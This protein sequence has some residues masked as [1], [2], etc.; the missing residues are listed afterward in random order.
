MS[1]LTEVPKKLTPP[2]SE[3]STES[4]TPIQWFRELITGA[5]SV[6]ILVIASVTLYG[7]WSF[8]RTVPTDD[9]MIAAQKEAYE[10]QKDIMLYAL[11]LLGTVT[12]YYLGRVPAE[13]HAQQAQRSA[14]SA[15]HELQSTQTKLTS[16]ASSAAVAA[17]QL[18]T[19]QSEKEKAQ[20]K[21]QDAKNALLEVSQQIGKKIAESPKT[22]RN[23]LS[24]GGIE[25]GDP[26]LEEMRK[27]KE[28]IDK[29]LQQIGD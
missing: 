28:Q 7:T 29:V 14:N 24:T 10:R 27:T 9:K 19:A 18:S 20:K 26:D 12:G 15:Q 8:A 5:I 25:N 21:T 2:H 1:E 17:S 6:A 4:S 22:R 11:A 16:T 23:V 3:P 13:L